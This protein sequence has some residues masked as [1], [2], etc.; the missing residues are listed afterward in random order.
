MRRQKTGGDPA[1]APLRRDG[2]RQDF[3]LA[4]GDAG[5]DKTRQM[6][7]L[8]FDRAVRERPGRDKK[9]FKIGFL[10]GIGEARRVDGG[11]FPA[12]LGTDGADARRSFGRPTIC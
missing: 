12:P 1:A 7:L 9:L 2:D 3:G 8:G 5:E 11:A 10:P 6:L 4:G